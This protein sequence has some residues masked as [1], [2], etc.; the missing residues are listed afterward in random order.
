MFLI[1]SEGLTHPSTS[2][3]RPDGLL[4]KGKVKRK[5][6]LCLSFYEGL[7]HPSTSLCRPSGLFLSGKRKKKNAEE[8]RPPA[9]FAKLLDTISAL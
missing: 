6:L 8:Q 1:I 3:C 5:G 2:L 4:G 9:T 7:T